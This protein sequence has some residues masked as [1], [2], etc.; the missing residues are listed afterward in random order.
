MWAVKGLSME[1][2][3]CWASMGVSGVVFALFVLDATIKIPFGGL[4]RVVDIIGAL[5]CAMVFYMAYDTFKEM[6]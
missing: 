3:L 1:K 5:A 6:H 2:W 4:N